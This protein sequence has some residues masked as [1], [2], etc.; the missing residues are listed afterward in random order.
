MLPLTNDDTQGHR[1]KDRVWACVVC[2]RAAAK[3]VE[4]LLTALEPQVERVLVVDNSPGGD[5]A[6]VASD[7]VGY[8]PMPA[9]LGTAGAMNEAWRL[10]SEAGA[11]Y[12]ISFDQ[13]SRPDGTLVNELLASLIRLTRDGRHVAAIGPRKTDPRSGQPMRILKPVTFRKRY[14]PL[15][16][17]GIVDVDHLISSGCL[18]PTGAFKR[19]GPYNEALFLDYV[20]IEWCLRA[21]AQGYAIVCD[22]RLAMPHVIGD[23]VLRIGGRLMW[24]HEPKRNG[25]LVRNHLL[26]WRAPGASLGWLLSDLRLVLMK[27]LVHLCVAPPRGERVA[28]IARGI[29][30]GLTGRGGPI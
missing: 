17:A 19:V 15:D 21:R 8:V 20:D 30:D 13:D 7:R 27:V 26:L 4:A 10:A 14:A 9:N 22:T 24:V 11:D 3:A 12:M 2:F 23:R 29:R 28:W 1:T 5:L 25:V 16:T 18:I 6:N